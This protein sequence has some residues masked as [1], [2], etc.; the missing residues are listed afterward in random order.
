MVSLTRFRQV[1]DLDADTMDAYDRV[2]GV[3]ALMQEATVPGRSLGD[4]FAAC[5]AAYAGLGFVQNEWHN[6]H[7]GGATGYAGRTCKATPGCGFP[8]LEENWAL[9]VRE[10]LGQEV[11]FGSAFAWN[12]SAPGVKSEDTFILLPD[13][14]R[15]I[16]SN[17]PELPRVNLEAVLGRATEVVKS[18]MMGSGF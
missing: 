9:R 16:V 17:T 3:D 5:Q 18:G 14:R 12:P 6:H 4:V 1:A 13:G 15:E 11:H 10:I 7:Q 2:C 8:V